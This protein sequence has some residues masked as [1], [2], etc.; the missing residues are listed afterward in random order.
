LIKSRT[1][2]DQPTSCFKCI[3]FPR[4]YLWSSRFERTWSLRALNVAGVS[5]GILLT[6]RRSF[7]LSVPRCQT[8]RDVQH[9]F[10]RLSPSPCLP[11]SASGCDGHFQGFSSIRSFFSHHFPARNFITCIGLPCVADDGFFVFSLLVALGRIRTFLPSK[12]IMFIG[13]DSVSTCIS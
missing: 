9:R 11:L 1:G 8:V 4:T 5:A 3:C 2:F 13:K 6:V 7:G 12:S 10:P